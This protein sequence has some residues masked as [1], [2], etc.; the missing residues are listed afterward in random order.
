VDLPGGSHTITLT[1]TDGRGGIATDTVDVFVNDIDP[2]TITAATAT[3]NVLGA[4]NH[5]MVPVSIAVSVADA[6]GPYTTCRIV[7]V[8]SS[9]PVNGLGDGDSSPDWEITGPLSLLLRAERAQR[10]SRTYMV[11]IE[12]VDGARLASR[13]SVTVTVPRS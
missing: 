8:S 5:Q 6:C 13:T 7:S 9:D 3:P 12:C 10:G 1:V 2:P 11:M 4:P